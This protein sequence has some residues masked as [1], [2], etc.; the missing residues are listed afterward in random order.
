MVV[1]LPP[2]TIPETDQQMSDYFVETK[3]CG[4]CGEVSSKTL[5]GKV[6]LVPML[7]SGKLNRLC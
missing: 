7:M 2:P 4:P 3:T 1:D 5:V 6:R